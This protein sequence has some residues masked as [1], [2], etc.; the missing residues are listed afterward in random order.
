MEVVKL[1]VEVAK[2][3]FFICLS[4]HP[5]WTPC[6]T[7]KLCQQGEEFGDGEF[8]GL[9]LFAGGSLRLVVFG[10]LVM[11][12]VIKGPESHQAIKGQWRAAVV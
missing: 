6:L 12:R 3:A 10:R 9:Y 1:Q 11:K 2:K 5:P 7:K 8:G 4:S